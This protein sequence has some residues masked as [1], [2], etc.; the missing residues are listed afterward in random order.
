M[1]QHD[2][3]ALGQRL[4]HPRAHGQPGPSIQVF[5]EQPVLDQPTSMQ[6]IMAQFMQQQQLM[7]QQMFMMQSQWMA[8]GQQHGF[9]TV[10]IRIQLFL[11]MGGFSYACLADSPN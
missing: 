4:P 11:L 8:Q 7:Q 10:S 9:Q 1:D 2:E 6:P 5:S 3:E